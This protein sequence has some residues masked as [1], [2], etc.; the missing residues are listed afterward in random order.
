MKEL[1]AMEILKGIPGVKIVSG[2]RRG[3]SHAIRCG[4]LTFFIANVALAAIFAATHSLTAVE[5]TNWIVRLAITD[6][7]VLL[8]YFVLDL[9]FC[10]RA[11]RIHIYMTTELEDAGIEE[12]IKRF[13]VKCLRHSLIVWPRRVS[14]GG[15]RNVL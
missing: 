3:E 7:G 2:D 14:T 4:C 10:F 8:V 5:M 12:I 15:E 9:Y 11:P 1:E 13:H 6:L